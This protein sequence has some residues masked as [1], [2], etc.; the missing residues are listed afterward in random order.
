MILTVT[1]AFITAVALA[2]AYDV[3]CVPVLL[4]REFR[5]RALLTVILMTVAA[6]VEIMVLATFAEAQTPQALIASR[7]KWGQANQSGDVSIIPIDNQN[8]TMSV[9]VSADKSGADL[10][11]IT[12]V[13]HENFTQSAGTAANNAMVLTL[14]EEHSAP[15]VSGTFAMGQRDFSVG[16]E[17]VVSIK[18]KLMKAVEEVSF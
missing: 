2:G 6:M 9:A 1:V 12:V 10:A 13:Y 3:F 15:L 11:L 14:T 4:K 16:R 8:G 5:S 18:V 7:I 17:K